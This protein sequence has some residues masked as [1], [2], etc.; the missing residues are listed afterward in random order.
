MAA[1]PSNL[2]APVT[3]TETLDCC[4]RVHLWVPRSYAVGAEYSFTISFGHAE[5]GEGGYM[6]GYGGTSPRVRAAS[7]LLKNRSRVQG[8]VG[9]DWTITD[10]AR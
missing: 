6:P 10:G 4:G 3:G 9:N 1:S 7:R 2:A 5:Y 8:A